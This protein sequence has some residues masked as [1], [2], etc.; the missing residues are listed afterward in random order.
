[1]MVD[2]MRPAGANLLSSSEVTRSRTE[3]ADPGFMRLAR[4]GCAPRQ[5]AGAIGDHVVMR[6]GEE[7]ALFVTSLL[8]KQKLIH[9]QQRL[10]V[11]V[12]ICG[13]FVA[14]CGEIPFEYLF[15]ASRFA[16]KRLRHRGHAEGFDKPGNGVCTGRLSV[17]RHVAPNDREEAGYTS[18]SCDPWTRVC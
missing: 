8:R 16:L 17:L 13:T 9:R 12:Q 1:M 3:S 7:V 14:Q 10:P 6:R 5:V 2:A 4:G 15:S 18:A 11:V